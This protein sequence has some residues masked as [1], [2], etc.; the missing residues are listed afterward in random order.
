[1]K[2]I[3]PFLIG[4]LLLPILSSCGENKAEKEARIEQERIEAENARIEQERKEQERRER[5]FTT[6]QGTFNT[7]RVLQAC[8]DKGIDNYN[9]FGAY[10]SNLGRAID[11]SW[12][13]E[14]K[15]K[16][17][18]TNLCGIPTNEKAKEVYKRAYDKYVEGWNDAANF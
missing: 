15:F 4:L 17:Y 14:D 1:M 8:Y 6:S 13:N 11:P 5:S 16:K 18:F 9:M 2:R 3:I 12:K 7:E 10:D